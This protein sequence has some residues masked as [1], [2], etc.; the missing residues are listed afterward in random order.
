MTM[1]G[2]LTPVPVW[3]SSNRALP[4]Q[5]LPDSLLG[6]LLVTVVTHVSTSLRC[7]GFMSLLG[8]GAVSFVG[9]GT[10]HTSHR[11]LS[12]GPYFR[13]PEASSSRVAG[14]SPCVYGTRLGLYS[15]SLP[16]KPLWWVSMFP[17][18]YTT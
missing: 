9:A 3:A 16:P 2:L 1:W 12:K 18:G 14:S 5:G 7:T 17:C 13:F 4:C 8:V 11:C 6:L 10:Q 15:C